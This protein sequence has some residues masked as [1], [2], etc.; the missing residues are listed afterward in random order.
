MHL[1][2]TVC[3]LKVV[4]QV[5]DPLF[6]VVAQISTHFFLALAAPQ[7]HNRNVVVVPT[8]QMP[9]MVTQVNIGKVF[10]YLLG[11]SNVLLL[12]LL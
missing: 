11:T 9:K 6:R 3:V 1:D 4:E 7:F 10:L 2:N 12:D 5:A 8:A